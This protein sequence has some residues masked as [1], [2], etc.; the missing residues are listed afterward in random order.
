MQVGNPDGPYPAPYALIYRGMAIFATEGVSI[1]PQHCGQ[2]MFGFFAAAIAINL[3]REVLPDKY[4]QWV[5]IPIA[6]AI[7][8]VLG[9]YLSIDMCIGGLI[10]AIWAYRS[11]QTVHL[12]ATGVAAGLIVGDGLWSV[13]QSILGASGVAA[14]LCTGFNMAPQTI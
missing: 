4:A 14:P 2:L 6:M 5:P 3:L 10:V 11:P 8:F 7:P 13:P 9:A 12:A 1:L